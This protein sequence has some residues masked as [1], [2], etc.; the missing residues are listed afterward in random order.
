MPLP[1]RRF[2]SLQVVIFNKGSIEQQGTPQVRFGGLGPAGYAAAAAQSAACRCRLQ[3]KTSAP[4][5][6]PP[7]P[8][9]CCVL[10][11]VAAAP[12]TPFVMNFVNDVNHVPA[13]CQ[14]RRQK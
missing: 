4:T 13:N 3:A 6:L 1:L 7:L 9:P 2:L 8:V 5:G 11:E 12:A 14:V 10:Q